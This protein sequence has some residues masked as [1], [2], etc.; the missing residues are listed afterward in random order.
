MRGGG[1]RGEVRE[2]SE[3][4]REEDTGRREWEGGGLE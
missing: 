3:T 1:V 4:K 2:E